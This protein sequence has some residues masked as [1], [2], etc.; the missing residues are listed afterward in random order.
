MKMLD[1]IGSYYEKGVL[2]LVQLRRP[3]PSRDS[4]FRLPSRLAVLLLNYRLIASFPFI[5]TTE[6][7]SAHLRK[8]PGF[9]SRMIHLKHGAG[10]REG[11]YNPRHAAYDLTLVM[12]E[13]DRERIIRSEE[14]TSELQSPMRI[15]YAVFCLKKKK[16]NIQT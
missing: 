15:S 6:V 11:G 1:F 7:S 10:D 16:P 9:S 3:F 13:K 8:V 2:E 12:G 4:L 5:A 14:H